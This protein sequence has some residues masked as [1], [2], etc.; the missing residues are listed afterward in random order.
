MTES[1]ASP[2]DKAALEKALR[3]MGLEPGKPLL[4][5]AIDVVFGECDR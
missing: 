5:R 3:Y 4:G 1:Q 2:S